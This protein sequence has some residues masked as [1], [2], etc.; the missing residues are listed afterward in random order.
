MEAAQPTMST[1]NNTF[2]IIMG[3]LGAVQLC[4]V[5]TTKASKNVLY[6]KALSWDQVLFGSKVYVEALRKEKWP[7]QHIRALINF[8]SK[9]DFQCTHLTSIPDKVFIEYQA[10]MWHEWMTNWNFDISQFSLTRLQAIQSRVTMHV[11]QTAL[12]S[13]SLA[14]TSMH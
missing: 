8:F 13:N 3:D 5:A 2:G 7:N 14:Y 4:P 11:H 10:T 6:N 12:I 1:S 9:L